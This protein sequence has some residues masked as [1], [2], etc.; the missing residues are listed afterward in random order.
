MMVDKYQF[1]ERETLYYNMEK[2]F[3]EF[4]NKAHTTYQAV[5][6]QSLIR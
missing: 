2:R 4:V 3:I 6:K 1:L 5:A